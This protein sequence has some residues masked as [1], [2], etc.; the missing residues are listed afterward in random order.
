MGAW[1]AVV[2]GVLFH[3]AI[4]SVRFEHRTISLAGV[5]PTGGAGYGTEPLVQNPT[6][7]SAVGWRLS[8]AGGCRD[9]ARIFRWDLHIALHRTPFGNIGPCGAGPL[10]RHGHAGGAARS[11]RGLWIYAEP[12]GVE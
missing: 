9:S 4:F 5:G 3:C 10:V 7:R 11:R 12:C 2:P 6:A 8:G 1:P